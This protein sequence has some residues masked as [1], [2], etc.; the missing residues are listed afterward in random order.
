MGRSFLYPL[1]HQQRFLHGL[2]RW[3]DEL[4]AEGPRYSWGSNIGDELWKLPTNIQYC[5]V[6]EG[7]PSAVCD[8]PIPPGGMAA[9]VAQTRAGLP[10]TRDQMH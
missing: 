8:E 9:L 2:V 5:L 1:G 7:L 10:P 4:V 6:R 3:G